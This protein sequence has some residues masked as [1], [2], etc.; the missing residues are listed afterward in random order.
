MNNIEFTTEPK[1]IAY[2][3]NIPHM[4]TIKATAKMFGLPEYFV[5]SKCLSG[6]IICVRAGRKILVNIDRF[7]EYLNSSTI[8]D[9]QDAQQGIRPIPVNL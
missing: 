4:E 3:S 9:E 7:S 5:R 2:S 8:N 6:E 1:S